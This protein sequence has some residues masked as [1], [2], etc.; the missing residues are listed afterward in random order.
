MGYTIT[1]NK[2]LRSLIIKRKI[3]KYIKNL[4]I[5][6]SK[7]LSNY[8]INICICD[9][10]QKTNLNGKACYFLEDDKIYIYIDETNLYSIKETLYHE[11][12]HF[13]DDIIGC[14]KN[15][16]LLNTS[17]CKKYRFSIT[18]EDF[19]FYN[20]QENDF[21]I[22]TIPIL[23]DVIFL[24]D[25]SESFADCFAE[26]LIGKRRFSMSR[27]KGIIYKYLNEYLSLTN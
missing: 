23:D 11:L 12:G 20:Q 18:N 25:L 9:I 22:Q 21:F 8:N 10:L 6:I 14:Y 15:N 4:P 1:S 16:K 3:Y 17:N 27:T 24:N 5:R 7:V 19:I 26:M 2:S 13:F